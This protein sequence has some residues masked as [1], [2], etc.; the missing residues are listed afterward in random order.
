MPPKK[1]AASNKYN[2]YR[3]DNIETQEKMYLVADKL[4]NNENEFE[5]K[6]SEFSKKQTVERDKQILDK[7]REKIQYINYRLSQC[8][9]E[10]K[11]RKLEGSELKAEIK[12]TE[13][14]IVY[15][16]R[17]YRRKYYWKG[18]KG[19]RYRKCRGNYYDKG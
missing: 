6:S 4:A 7:L 2:N 8:E 9:R 10:L 14:G 12:K 18:S 15:Y 3:A 5:N 1:T 13:R 17:K 19:E 16:Y 11:I